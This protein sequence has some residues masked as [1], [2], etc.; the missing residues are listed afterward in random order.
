MTTTPTRRRFTVDEYHC[1]EE[2][3]ILHEDDRIELIEG[4]ILLMPPIG[5]DH[6][7]GVNYLNQLLVRL[8][9]DR[10]VVS[11]QNPVRLSSHT[12]PEPDF[13]VL[14]PR[15]DFYRTAIPTA[16]DVLL[17]IEIAHSSLSYDRRIKLPLYAAAGISEVWIVAIPTSRVL[18]HRDPSPTGYASITEHERGAS[19]SPLA[20]PD[21]SVSVDEIL[22]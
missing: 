18:V 5:S 3:G 16:E 13:S 22:G 12:E 8:L 14:R 11:V 7:G 9:D 21:I 4:D 6:V 17:L 2:A 19:L 15:D 10:A 1:M 20:F